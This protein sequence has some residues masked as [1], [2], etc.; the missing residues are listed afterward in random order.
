M[1]FL[2]AFLNHTFGNFGK[3]LFVLFASNKSMKQNLKMA[4]YSEQSYTDSPY[5]LSYG[6]FGKVTFTAFGK[7][8]F[9][10]L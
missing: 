4:F 10:I 8:S 2:F 9:V 1:H 6:K 7:V 5:G 3:Q